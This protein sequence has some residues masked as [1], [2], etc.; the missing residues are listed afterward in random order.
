MTPNNTLVV[1]IPLRNHEHEQ[2]YLQSSKE[3]SES[4][5][6]LPYGQDRD[7]SFNYH[8]FH[9]SPF[10]PKIVHAEGQ[11]KLHMSLPMKNYRPEDI[12]VAVKNNDLIVQGKHISRDNQ[13]SENTFFYKSIALPPGTQTEH[14]QSQLTHDGN[15]QIEAPFLEWSS[16][17]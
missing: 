5:H 10:T 6:L 2:R 12:K 14:L 1:D 17:H 11:K 15:L 9:T 16:K 13:H 3:A 4:Q 8:H 7:Q